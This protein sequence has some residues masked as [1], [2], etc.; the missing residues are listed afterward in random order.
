MGRKHRGGYLA[1]TNP[2]TIEIFAPLSFYTHSRESLLEGKAQYSWP[3][4]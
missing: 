2:E 4:S 3:P 1:A